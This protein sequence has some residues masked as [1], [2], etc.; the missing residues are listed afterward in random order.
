MARTTALLAALATF[1]LGCNTVSP[2]Q[3]AGAIGN[4]PAGND[5]ARRPPARAPRAVE[6]YFCNGATKTWGTGADSGGHVY[7]GDRSKRD[8]P[9]RCKASGETGKLVGLTAAHN[10][11]RAAVGTNDLVWSSSLATYAQAWANQLAANGCALQHRSGDAYGENLFWKSNGATSAQVV[12]Q[13]TAEKA[14]YDHASN[15][16]SAQTC[17]HFTQVVWAGSTE[18]GCGMATCG[19]AEVWVCNYAPQGNILGQSPY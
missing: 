9:G 18:L 19:A 14:H 6:H 10:E 4:L 16:C 5:A 3:T 17:G 1:V 15:S 2:T 13:W 11:A 7:D 8:D 12:A